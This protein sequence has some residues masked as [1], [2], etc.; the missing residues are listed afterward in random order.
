MINCVTAQQFFRQYSGDQEPYYEEDL[1]KLSTITK[2]EHMKGSL[3]MEN[4]K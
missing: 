3:I 2:Q 4:F 1:N